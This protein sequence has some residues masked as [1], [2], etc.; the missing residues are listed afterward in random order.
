MAEGLRL[1]EGDK[2]GGTPKDLPLSDLPTYGDVARCFYKAC[3]TEDKKPAAQLNLVTNQL[4]NRWERSSPALPLF[5]EKSVRC[6][7]SRFV[8]KVKKV[9]KGKQCTQLLAG[10]ERL[11]DKLFDIAACTCD[12]VQVDCNNNRVQCRV[13][14]CAEDHLLCVCPPHKQVPIE[15]RVYLADQRGKVGTHGGGMQIG[16]PEVPNGDFFRFN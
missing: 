11:K 7:V 8:E 12:L 2:Y 9:N 3:E 1:D 10:L 6:K 13:P 15:D 4:I 16:R 14:N 5:S